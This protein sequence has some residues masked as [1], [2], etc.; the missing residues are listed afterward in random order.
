M[1]KNFKFKFLSVILVISIVIF[2]TPVHALSINES[3][4]EPIDSKYYEKF[5][6]RR[7]IWWIFIAHCAIIKFQFIIEVFCH[8]FQFDS[9]QRADQPGLADPYFCGRV[10]RLR[11]GH[12]AR[13]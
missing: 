10:D 13:V 3:N 9:C 11:G 7:R 2:I 12:G 1:K 5:I 8:V 4:I 6:K